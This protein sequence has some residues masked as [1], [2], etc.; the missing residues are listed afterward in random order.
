MTLQQFYNNLAYYVKPESIFIF[1]MDGTL[2]N[3]DIANF[4]A[5]S[6][7]LSPTINLAQ[8][9]IACR[10]T[11]ASLS[12][13]GVSRN[14]QESVI[15]QKREIYNKYLKDTIKMPLACKILEIVSKTNM[16]ILAT[17]SEKQRAI[18]TLQYHN[19][20]AKFTYSVFR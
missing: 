8:R 6:E 1:D 20:H 12:E 9:Y 7:A 4:N 17:Q 14:M 3:S 16:T 15:S 13:L 2:V 11:R 19:L 18:D 5:Y 10:I